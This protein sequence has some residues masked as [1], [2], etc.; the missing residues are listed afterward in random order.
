MCILN[1]KLCVF[2]EHKFRKQFWSN[3]AVEVIGIKYMI[4]EEFMGTDDGLKTC[5]FIPASSYIF[6]TPK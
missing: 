4:T 1:A 2:K 5:Q 6:L 3:I